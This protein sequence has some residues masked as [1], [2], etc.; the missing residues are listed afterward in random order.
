MELCLV[1]R[2]SLNWREV[3]G[4]WKHVYV[5]MSPFSAHL[6]LSQHCVLTGNTSTQNKRLGGKKN[7]LWI[8]VKEE[9]QMN[10]NISQSLLFTSNVNWKGSGRLTELAAWRSKLPLTPS[11]IH[12]VWKDDSQQE[13]EPNKTIFTELLHT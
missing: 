3:W 8:K 7:T 12:C 5:W 10:N 6:K 4:E 11:Y 1:L 13:K 2:G 9:I